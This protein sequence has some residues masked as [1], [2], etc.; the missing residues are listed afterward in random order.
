MRKEKF[1]DH[2]ENY[3]WDLTDSLVTSSRPS[4]PLRIRLYDRTSNISD[5]VLEAGGSRGT[6]DAAD[7]QC[8]R[9]QCISQSWVWRFVLQIS[10]DMCTQF[11][12]REQLASAA[13]CAV[14]L[15]CV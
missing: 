7:K 8:L 6:T 1:S 11:V 13:C 9:S 4:G 12:L 2:D 14:T 10:V 3:Q 15:C 5:A